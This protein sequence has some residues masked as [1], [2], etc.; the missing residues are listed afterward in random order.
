VTIRNN[1]FSSIGV[2][3]IRPTNFV[4]LAIQGNDITGVTEHGNHSDA[5]QTVF[6]GRNL[7][8]EANYIHD[9]KAEGI[10]I[11]DGEVTNAYIANNVIVHTTLE[12]QI[13]VFDTIGLK[14]VNNTLW[15]N[16]YNIV[17]RAGVRQGLIRDNIFENE[18]AANLSQ[19]APYIEQD[20]N[21]VASG[22]NWGARGAH[23]S[24]R[25][26]RF[27]DQATSDFR[28]A[29]GSAGID[30]GNAADSPRFDKACRRRYDDPGVRNRGSG[31][32]PFVDMGALEHGPT[33][34]PG[35]TA[36]AFRQAC[37]ALPFGG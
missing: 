2:D 21:L 12:I 20:H 32:P 19:S 11:K 3:A 23:D 31:A 35:D 26:P 34:R 1:H 30:A 18:V 37:G 15:D 5:I 28:L 36:A 29:N 10:L 27:V 22:W 14:I 7:D 9:N 13:Q 16:Q 33:S 17:L 24:S 4:N 25:R 6:G 8:I